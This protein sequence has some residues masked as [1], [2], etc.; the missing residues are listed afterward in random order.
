MFPSHWLRST[1]FFWT[2]VSASCFK[3]WCFMIKR[4]LPWWLLFFFGIFL[5]RLPVSLTSGTLVRSLMVAFWRA[6]QMQISAGRADTWRVWIAPVPKEGK[7]PLWIL[8]FVQAWDMDFLSPEDCWNLG[9]L[10]MFLPSFVSQLPCWILWSGGFQP[11][12]LEYSGKPPEG[13]MAG[14]RRDLRVDLS[15]ES[16][17]LVLAPVISSFPLSLT[18][19]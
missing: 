13:Q 14:L 7:F 4:A 10:S 9:K 3:S 15:N 19:L 11:W 12:A 17:N 2:S 16:P 18:E 6:H 8:L 1:T 5:L